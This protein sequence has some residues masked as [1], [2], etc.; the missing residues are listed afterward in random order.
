MDVSDEVPEKNTIW[1]DKERLGKQGMQEC[2][3]CLD[4]EL[5]EA[6]LFKSKGKIVDARLDRVLWMYP[7]NAT[8]GRRTSR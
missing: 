2:F 3:E 6:G 8:A 1:N 4:K 7:S 5:R